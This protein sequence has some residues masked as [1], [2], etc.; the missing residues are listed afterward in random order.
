VNRFCTALPSVTTLCVLSS[1]WGCGE[2][3]SCDGLYA[4]DVIIE[5]DTTGTAPL[6][7]WDQG[8]SASAV[9]IW[10]TDD[11]SEETWHIQ[12]GDADSLEETTCI[13][14]PLTYGETPSSQSLDTENSTDARELISG[15]SY[16]V[17]VTTYTDSGDASCGEGH[18]GETTFLAP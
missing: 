7:R 13:T 15:E 1:L 5:V 3:T 6:L 2:Y 11:D 17:S 10:P 12:C 8:G 9:S 14:S 16:T 4:D 18:T